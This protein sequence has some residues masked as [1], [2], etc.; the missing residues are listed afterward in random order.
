MP[1]FQKATG[2]EMRLVTSR[3]VISRKRPRRD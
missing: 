1:D 3:K 2:R